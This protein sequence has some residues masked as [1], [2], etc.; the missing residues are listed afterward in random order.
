M[1]VRTLS[2]LGWGWLHCMHIL[3]TLLIYILFQKR[4]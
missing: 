4:R 3:C 1:P 2:H